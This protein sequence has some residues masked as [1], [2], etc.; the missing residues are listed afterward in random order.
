[1]SWRKLI[2][3]LF[4]V[5]M[6]AAMALQPACMSK[7]DRIRKAF[8]NFDGK[9]VIYVS[10]K[11]FHLSVYNRRIEVVAGYTIA[12]GS[13]PDM[14]AKLYEGDNRTPEGFYRVNEI[15]SMDAD[16]KSDAYRTLRDMNKKY[17]RA[18]EGHSKYGEP[19]MDLG[20]NAYGPRYFEIDYPGAADRKRYARAL[21]NGD[22]PEKD[23][24]V[25]RIGY[26]IAI[27]GNNDENSVGH[28][29]S[30]GCVRLYNRDIVEFE[31]YIQMGTPVI[32]SAD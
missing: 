14:K 29:S 25:A 27:H 30:N 20:D 3:A 7:E 15:L 11:D 1:M 9:Y 2:S 17:F 22:I 10:K 23:G 28:L 12:Y 32:I 6:I 24:K 16:K 4:P 13:N 5:C 21:K 19:G 26:G 8:K 18:R 31:Q